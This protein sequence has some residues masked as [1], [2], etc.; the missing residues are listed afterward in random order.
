MKY[1]CLVYIEESVMAALSPAE[2]ASLNNRSM[3]FDAGLAA[4]GRLVVAQ[5]LHPPRTAVTIRVRDGRVSRTDGPFA[6]TK[7][8]LGGFFL[9]DAES[10]EAAIALAADSPMA[11]VGSIEV[12]PAFDMVKR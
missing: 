6:E 12:R 7:E 10:L 2:G 3:D 5:P 8:H 1:A 11:Q 9:V 4:D